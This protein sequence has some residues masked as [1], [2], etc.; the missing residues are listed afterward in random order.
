MPTQQIMT[1][2]IRKNERGGARTAAE[3]RKSKRLWCGSHL[4]A[5]PDVQQNDSVSDSES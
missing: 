3:Y 4:E 2:S 1:K 5:T